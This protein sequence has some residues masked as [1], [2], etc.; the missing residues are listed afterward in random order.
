V[1]V[2]D[3]RREAGQ[4]AAA[5]I[6]GRGAERGEAQRVVRPLLAVRAVYGLPGRP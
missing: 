4:A 6:G 5:E 2:H 3:T 1:R